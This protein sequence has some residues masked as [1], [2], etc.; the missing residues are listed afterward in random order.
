MERGES[1]PRLPVKAS[2][3]AMWTA[4]FEVLIERAAKA[5]PCPERKTATNISEPSIQEPIPPLAEYV[6]KKGLVKRATRRDFLK[7]VGLATVGGLVTGY[8]SRKGMDYLGGK[9]LDIIDTSEREIRLLARDVQVLSGAVEQKLAQE[10]AKLEDMYTKGQFRKFA[11][12][13]IADPA[14]ISEFEEILKNSEEFEKRYSFT[15]RT[16]EFVDRINNRI[17]S[18][19]RKLEE[20]QPG[21]LQGLNDVMRE[22]RRAV[23]E[24]ILGRE[25]VAGTYTKKLN[26]LCEIYDTNEDNRVAEGKVLEKINDYLRTDKALLTEERE[27]FAFLKNQYEQEGGSG[28]VKE[29]VKSYNKTDARS[30]ALIKLK[31]NIAEAETLYGQIK[32]NKVYIQRLQGYLK[33]GIS[34]EEEVRAKR[35]V[36]FS[37]QKAEVDQKVL[38]LKESV[39]DII[40]E[41][42]AKGYEIETR[43]DIAN[44]KT[45]GPYARQAMELLHPLTSW[46]PHI[47]GGLTAVITWHLRRKSQK[48]RNTDAALEDLAGKHNELSDKYNEL[49]HK[50]YN[51]EKP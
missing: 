19:D 28:R 24:K 22:A 2:D 4:D 44:K 9:L 42:K 36:E 33:E 35:A 23:G 40:K 49:I 7:T 15:K 37:K 34:L 11:D 13:G 21:F 6:T 14:E 10:T 8:G 46:A 3:Q 41:L 48:L 38:K 26:A 29:F 1:S 16:G 50:T 43:Q 51:D 25:I 18:V 39:D 5:V 47:V 45:W 20:Q 17:L 30:D 12:L 32:E 31:A 27:L